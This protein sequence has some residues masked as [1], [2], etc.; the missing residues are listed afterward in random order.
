MFGNSE[1]D[2]NKVHEHMT[3]GGNLLLERKR[4]AFD[5]AFFR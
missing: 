2:L 4:L 5:G 3:G 1:A